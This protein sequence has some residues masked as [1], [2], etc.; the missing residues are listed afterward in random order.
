MTADVDPPDTELVQTHTACLLLT[1]SRVLK[2][3]KP[4]DL[5]FVD[6]RGREARLAACRA[7]VALNSRLAPDVY[8]G[9]GEVRDPEGRPYEP[10]VLMRRMPAALRLSTLVRDDQDVDAHVDAV[11]RTLAD[12][13]A[14]C[15]VPAD[16]RDVAS[17]RRLRELWD[18][19]L[20]VLARHLPLRDVDRAVAM[21]ERYLAGRAPLLAER[22]DRGCVR[23]G[24]GDLLADDIFCLPDGPRI[25]D[26][27]DFAP[28]LRAGDVVGDV[29][30]LAMDLEHLGAPAVAR[31][32]WT[33]YRQFTG[34]THPATLEHLYTAYRAAVRAKV[35]CVRAEQLPTSE[36]S[37]HL[38]R[39]AAL[40]GLSLRHLERTR[41]RLVLVGGLPASGS[42][43]LA[44]ALA[45]HQ[46]LL[47]H[48]SDLV[49]HELFGAAPA[50]EPYEGPM[51]G[52][53]PT[54]RVYAVLLERA[55]TELERGSSVVLDASWSRAWQRQAARDLAS[56]TC[57][58]LVELDCQVPDPVAEI[59][60]GQRLP[61]HPSDADADVRREMRSRA[62]P[63]PTAHVIDTAGPVQTA[64][65]HALR[66]LDAGTEE[67]PL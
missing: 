7:E 53:P 67:R 21:L 5:G 43:T 22:A 31:R 3:K 13:H 34:E 35:A 41:L 4:V 26:C 55:R 11:A 49:R 2:W 1:G 17:P 36:R 61:T 66:L 44:A 33:R 45:D 64:L 39:A 59:R 56:D 52:A 10:Y 63:W 47:L 40:F 46:G 60:L 30:F 54:R 29:A 50:A 42:S 16:A 62:D 65:D 28:E 12:F 9:V 57:G 51:Y 37:E 20:V 24:H 32:L 18:D 19:A 25:L 58:E 14:R 23:D 15:E 8:L 27:L 48:S 6:F 38:D